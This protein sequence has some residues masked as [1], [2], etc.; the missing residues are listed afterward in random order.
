MRMTPALRTLFERYRRRAGTLATPDF[1]KLIKDAAN[2]Q[3]RWTAVA[4]SQD[5]ADFI[6]MLRCSVRG[7]YQDLS[8]SAIGIVAGTL[9]YVVAP[10]D[11]LPDLLPAV[12]FIDDFTVIA[13]AVNVVRKEIEHFRLW[14]GR[15][16][17]ASADAES[18]AAT[19]AP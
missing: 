10:L 6:D 14:R 17:R 3:T 2:K 18:H 15:K 19:T 9:L 16:T 12:G 1:L 11:L 7:E 5:L 4:G 13:F 8:K